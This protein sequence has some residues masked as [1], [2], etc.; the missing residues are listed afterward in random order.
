MT[1]PDDDEPL[2]H[3]VMA[4]DVPAEGL[5]GHLEAREAERAQIAARFDLI[6]L[7]RLALSYKLT[8]MGAG[9][10]LL[11]GTWNAEVVQTCGVTLDPL[12]LSLGDDVRVEFWSPE[13]WERNT[14]VSG[15][16]AVEPED[17]PPEPIEDGAMD[18]ARLLEQLLSLALPSFPRS[19]DA[20]LDWDERDTSGNRPFEVLK[21]L[22][23]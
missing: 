15:E 13:V 1:G 7:D 18:I 23:S 17:E 19:D 2:M 5:E 11:N 12:P 20:E 8:R 21:K 14:A 16:I 22:S 9:R 3:T 4:E 6:S 10:F